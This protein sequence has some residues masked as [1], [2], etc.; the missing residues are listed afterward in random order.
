MIFIYLF[1]ELPSLKVLFTLIF[2]TDG[3]EVGKYQASHTEISA[4]GERV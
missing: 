4:C 1:Y 2:L 3:W